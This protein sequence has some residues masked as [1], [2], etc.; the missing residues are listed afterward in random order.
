ME[1][2]RFNGTEPIAW[3]VPAR[4]GAGIGQ[5]RAGEGSGRMKYFAV[6]CLCWMTSFLACPAACAVTLRM[7]IPS[8]ATSETSHMFSGLFQEFEAANPG[9]EVEFHPLTDWDDVVKVIAETIAHGQS[10]GMF[11]AEA[12]ETYELENL[13]LILPFAGVLGGD[14]KKFTD[15][16]VREF[17]GNSSCSTGTFCAPPFVQS[18][19][20]AMYNL[21]M[22]REA[23]ISG[24]ALPANWE[25]LEGLLEK[26][27]AA[28]PGQPPFA[29][30]GD[31]YDYLFEAMVRQA[32]GVLKDPRS[33]K[34]TLDTPEALKALLF[35]KRLQ[36]RGL[37]MRMNSWKATINAFQEGLAAV[38][39]YSSGGLETVH[40]KAKFSWTADRLPG[41]R[42]FSVALGGGNL[43][44]AANL[45][46]DEK[47][48]ASKLSAFLY[49]PG[50]QAR[51]S[52]GSGFFPVVQAAFD[53][54]A[55]QGRYTSDEPYVRVRSQ[56]RFS[57]PKL[58]TAHYLEVRG[59]LKRAI[60]RTLDE[61]MD[62][63]ESLR[64]AQGEVDRLL[65]Q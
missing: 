19:P 32:G 9:I 41:D 64:Q 15:M 1:A 46:E 18:T 6:A 8:G 20:V 52:A 39:Y 33:R 17:L 42:M 27:K 53:D 63:G 48:A 50:V 31:W 24:D 34:V 12:S 55:L 44:L 21:D 62:A 38:A 47:Q 49:S 36:D 11:V 35:W 13:G 7:T 14:E 51:I 60:D 30:G 59:I 28:R 5:R 25:E 54:P 61:G 45:S 56:L 37:L 58:M 2:G 43:Y 22:L 23:G 57:H 10:G 40:R 26:V 65:E 16:F 4:P 3:L 29:L